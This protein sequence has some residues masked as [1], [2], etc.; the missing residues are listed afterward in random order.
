M[1]ECFKCL[2]EKELSEFYKHPQMQDGHVN[3][4]KECNKVDVRVNYIKN[5]SHYSAYEKKRAMI[6]HRVQARELY[7]KTDTGKKSMR[8]SR[9]KYQ[10][11]YPNAYKTKIITG[12]AIRGGKIIR[13]DIC[14]ECPSSLGIEGHH[15]DYNKPLEVRWLCCRCHHLWHKTNTPLNR[16]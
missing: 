11:N 15:D 7:Q 3:K 10:D 13:P 6:P 2:K 12:S 9:K 1:K 8:K 14:E 16:K 5:I 4:C